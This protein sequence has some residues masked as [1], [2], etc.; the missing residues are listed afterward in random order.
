MLY[1][2][3]RSITSQ[4]HWVNNTG[5]T[6]RTDLAEIGTKLSKE[7]L[8]KA[9]LHPDDG[10]SFGYEGFVFKLKDGNQLLGY[11]TSETKDEVSVKMMGGSV[12]RVKKS[13]LVQKK[14]YEHSLMPA[15]LVSGMQQ[16]QVVDLIEYMARLKKN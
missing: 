5:I 2:P 9:V 6:L 12:T 14:S 13:D 16:Q 8:Y 3:I 1:F 10:I 15:G 11:V 4:E 7:A